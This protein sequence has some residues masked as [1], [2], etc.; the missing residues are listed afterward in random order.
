M[1]QFLHTFSV[2][3]QSTTERHMRDGTSFPLITAAVFGMNKAYCGYLT[4]GVYP[5]MVA[6]IFFFLNKITR[7]E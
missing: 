7:Q 2:S 5:T 1:E 6:L 4:L 3:C